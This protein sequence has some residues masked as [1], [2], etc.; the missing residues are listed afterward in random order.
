MRDIKEATRGRWYGILSSLGIQVHESGAHGPCPICQA[1]V[2]R[3]RWDNKRGDGGYF[4]NQCI[5]K[6]GDGFDLVMG[7]LNVDFKG[8]VEAIE[9]IIGSADISKPQ[10]EKRISKELLRKIYTE[11]KPLEYN[12]PAS[13]YLRSRGL[14]VTSNKL[15]YH[16]ACYEPET[17]TKMRAMLATYSLAEGTAITLHRTFL[18]ANGGGKADIKNPKKILPA[19]KPM[20]GG[21]IRLFDLDGPVLCVAEGIESALAVYELTGKP[22]WSLV[23]ATLMESFK[24]PREVKEVWVFGDNDVTW[25]GQKA[26]Y[27]LANR[28]IVQNKLVVKVY[29]PQQPGDFLDD[30]IKRKGG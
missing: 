24:P 23:S 22:T 4:C 18:S 3:F 2:D 10:P 12:D 17:H 7:C 8:A 13:A 19:L 26:A 5:K 29:I 9:R 30:L 25:T 6:S 27:T 1:G 11:S 21:A 20:A 28:L 16:P 14:A 15:R